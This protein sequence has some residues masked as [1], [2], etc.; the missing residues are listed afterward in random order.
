MHH[1]EVASRVGP[2]VSGAAHEWLEQ[3]TRPI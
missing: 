2:L 1:A 3:R